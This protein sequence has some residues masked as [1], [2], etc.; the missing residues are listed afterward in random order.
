M[1]RW[2]RGCLTFVVLSALIVASAYAGWRW[3]DA[4]FDEGP[5]GIGVPEEETA[6]GPGPG[7]ELARETMARVD[8]FRAGGAEEA[9]SELALGS[10]EVASVVR[11]A[12]PGVL[13]ASMTRPEL[14]IESGQVRISSH[15]AVDEVPPVP[16]LERVLGILPD[17]VPITV[18]ASLMPFGDDGAALVVHR[19]HASGVPLPRRIIPPVLAALGRVDRPGLPP[20]AIEVSLPDG[21]RSAYI[22]SD[23]L[24]L[25]AAPR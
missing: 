20:T 23:S 19:I 1:L 22:L 14:E 6:A 2:L 24:V 13:P 3:G 4:V 18:E 8:A 12:A 7:P 17:T 11:Y 16:E 15:I 21:V 10:A 25:V 5:R 9:G